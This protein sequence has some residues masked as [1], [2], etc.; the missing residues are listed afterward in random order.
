MQLILHHLNPFLRRNALSANRLLN[1]LVI[2]ILRQRTQRTL[3]EQQVDVLQALLVC[4]DEEEVDGRDRDDDVE[5]AEDLPR[6]T[7]AVATSG[8]EVGRNSQSSTSK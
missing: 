1:I 4:L 3:A 7:S 8:C 2:D 5:G 6:K